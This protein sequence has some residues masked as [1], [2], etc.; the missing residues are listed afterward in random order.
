MFPSGIS[1]AAACALSGPTAI[2][3]GESADALVN[4][5]VENYG[6]RQRNEA[7]ISEP[8][9]DKRQPAEAATAPSLPRR[10]ESRPSNTDFPPDRAR[11][12][13]GQ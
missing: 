3:S 2:E 6:T 5:Y 7:S 13:A 8:A 12:V 4:R 10:S 11:R 1:T 9:T